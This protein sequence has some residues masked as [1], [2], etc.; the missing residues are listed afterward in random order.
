MVSRGTLVGELIQK[1][2]AE[3]VDRVDMAST[4]DKR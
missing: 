1:Q 3:N 4:E 2:V